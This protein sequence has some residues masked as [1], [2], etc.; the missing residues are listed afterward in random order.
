MYGR[1]ENLISIRIELPEE[2]DSFALRIPLNIN[3]LVKIATWYSL[4]NPV[5]TVITRIWTTS[6]WLNVF[7]KI[8]F[9]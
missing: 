2:M 3:F 9:N 4:E 5:F 7:I 8:Y 6:A 1:D